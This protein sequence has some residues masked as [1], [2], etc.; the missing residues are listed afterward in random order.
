[1]LKVA[2]KSRLCALFLGSWIVCLTS[3]IT[4]ARCMVLKTSSLIASAGNKTGIHYCSGVMLPGYKYLIRSSLGTISHSFSSPFSCLGFLPLVLCFP[5]MEDKRGIKRERSP[6]VE[7]SYAPSNTKTPPLASSGSPSPPGSPS[8]V[9]SRH[10]CSS[11]FEQGGPSEKASV[12]DLSSSSD[13]E[14]FIANTSCDF[15]FA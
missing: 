14:D 6:S 13:E 1:V 3:W 4:D 10:P 8:E 12:I 15:E 11:V 7:G 9:A 2:R 5:T